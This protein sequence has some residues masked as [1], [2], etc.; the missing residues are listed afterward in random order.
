MNIYQKLI[1]GTLSIAALVAAVG[2]VSVV[3]SNKVIFDI[4][5][6]AHSSI[7]EALSAT[8]MGKALQSSHINLQ[9]LMVIY[10]QPPALRS[11]S[12]H[13]TPAV[14]RARERIDNSSREFARQLESSRAATR[15]GLQMALAGRE[16]AASA[17]EKEELQE[18]QE[19]AQWHRDYQREQAAIVALLDSDPDAARQRLA[20]TLDP[21]YHRLLIEV[22]EIK[23]EAV[24]EVI[25]ETQ[26]IEL[27]AL[28]S[29]QVVLTAALVALL[30]ALLLGFF[31]AR[32]V[33]IPLKRFRDAAVSIG[34][35]KLDTR[36]SFTAKDEMGSL[37]RA[38]NQ[39]VDKLTMATDAL[40]DAKEYVDNI[41]NS[42]IDTLIVLRPD[43]TIALVNRA[44][45][46]LLGY[47]EQELIGSSIG[48]ILKRQKDRGGEQSVK[49]YIEEI[50]AADA[51]QSIESVYLTS[52]GRE[53]PMLLS[54]AA[55]YSRGGDLLGTVC[56]AKDLTARKRVEEKLRQTNVSL[57]ASNAELKEVQ[58]Q[59]VQAAK[60][61][62]IGELATGIAHEIN[63]PLSYISTVLQT[64]PQQINSGHCS[65]EQIT[66]ALQ[67]A[68]QRVGRMT[69]IIQHLR[70]FGRKQGDGFEQ[71]KL[72]T[73]LDD[74]LLLVGERMR[75][76]NID[77]VREVPA[78][79]P[80][81]TGNAGQLEQILINLFQNAIDAL[82]SFEGKR[83]I[84]VTMQ[85]DSDK[86]AIVIQ[87]SDTGPGIS[88][89]DADKI[90]DPFYTT[91]PAGKGTGLGLSI[92]YG[93][94]R[95]HN[96]TIRH[97]SKRQAAAGGDAAAA[98]N[99]VFVITLPI[100]GNG[101]DST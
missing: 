92:A 28:R 41:I 38:F 42:M 95:A 20:D 13:I 80:A 36:I 37:A 44:A 3:Q 85:V 81:V 35:G 62:S 82:E 78:T 67:S 2:A 22:I 93:I 32:S 8:A 24:G 21:L 90:F 30:A 14:V 17:R 58:A 97:I 60:L 96:G 52:S 15:R 51:A 61:A 83:V 59:L 29:K 70:T 64:V 45:V 16:Q 76:G 65:A 69:T 55:M 31:I 73:V 89:Q 49:K 23:Q 40:T 71:V 1:V 54:A 57:M 33:S 26:H 12:D 63:Q 4:S 100:A 6:F 87:F 48:M 101:R 47:T 68:Y 66:A 43:N 9:R 98:A 94:I 46:D 77:F 27:Q 10:A 53:N 11:G 74:S 86:N 39:M 79:L 75:I 18:L 34:A 99:T 7:N 91:K 50:V 72:S 88:E 25:D 19:L 5:Q 56:V 84:A